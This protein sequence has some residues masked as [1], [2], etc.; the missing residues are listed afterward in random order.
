MIVTLEGAPAVGKS[1][2]AAHLQSAHGCY[3]VPEANKL[4]GKDNRETN[5]RY[6]QKQVERWRLAKQERSQ[7][8]SILDGD[9]FQPIWFSALFADEDWG[10]FDQIVNFFNLALRDGSIEFPDLY[11]FFFVDENLRA[12]REFE[13]SEALGR[14]YES[15][16]K[17]IAKYRQF[18][19]L[20]K[21][22]FSDLRKKFPELVFFLESKDLFG[23]AERIVSCRKGHGYQ[24]EDI[25]RFIVDWCREKKRVARS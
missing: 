8:F 15:A 16:V 19:G 13:R 25:R 22:Y 11:I 17:K 18:A 6:C 3:V 10:D 5:L 4:F 20:Q 23:S 7:N 21:E 12:Q 9:I 14:S 1:T 24:G 2:V